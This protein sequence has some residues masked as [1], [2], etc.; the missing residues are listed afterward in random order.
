MRKIILLFLLQ[1]LPLAIFAK[2]NIEKRIVYLWDVTYSMHGGY[3][4]NPPKNTANHKTW[5]LEIFFKVNP[6]VSETLNASIASA[7]AINKVDMK[8]IIIS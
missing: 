1:C 8:S 7:I 3:A 6:F 5:L 2:G 4:W